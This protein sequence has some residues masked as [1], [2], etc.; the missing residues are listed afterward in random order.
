[1]AMTAHM[2]CPLPHFAMYPLFDNPA[3]LEAIRGVYRRG[4]CE[5]RPAPGA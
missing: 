1:M 4:A 2:G 5:P 3:A